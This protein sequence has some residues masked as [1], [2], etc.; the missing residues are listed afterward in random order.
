MFSLFTHNPKNVTD[1]FEMWLNGNHSAHQV[2]VRFQFYQSDH[3]D[4]VGKQI[5]QL[6]VSSFCS[7]VT[8]KM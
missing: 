8:Q 4:C 2:P 1:T 6:K 5:L 3:L 7:Q